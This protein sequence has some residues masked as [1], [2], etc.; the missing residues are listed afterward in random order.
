[1]ENEKLIT[2][3]GGSAHGKEGIDGLGGVGWP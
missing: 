3:L 1:M 2:E